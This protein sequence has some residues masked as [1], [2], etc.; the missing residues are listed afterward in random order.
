MPRSFSHVLFRKHVEDLLIRKR[1]EEEETQLQ[2]IEDRVNDNKKKEWFTQ[3]ERECSV[4]RMR[5]LLSS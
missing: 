3:R 5:S 1:G 2:H 4:K